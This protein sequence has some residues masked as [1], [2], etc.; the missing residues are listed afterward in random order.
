M[1]GRAPSASLL[2]RAERGEIGGVI[3]LRPQVDDERQ[4]RA[5]ATALQEAATAGGQPP[6]LL[7]ADQEGGGVRTLGWAQPEE[8]ALLMGRRRDVD[9]VRSLGAAAGKALVGA[10]LNVDLAPVGDVPGSGRS[11]MRDSFRTWSDDPET[12]GRFAG[13]FAEGLASQDVLA[14]AKHFPGIGRVAR[15]TDRFVETVTESREALERDLEP[16]RALIDAG[17]PLV[18][19]SNATYEAL[20]PD[21]AAGW[22]EAVAGDLLR[23]DL[24]F[25]GVTITD[26]LNGTAAA[27]DVPASSLAVAA[28]RAGVDLVLLTGRERS[29]ADAYGLLLREARE[30]TLDRATLEAGHARI[31]ALKATLADE[32]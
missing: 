19:L 22:S 28:A 30:G 27:R 18:M 20:D 5:A 15:N 29:T 10:G 4:L 1:D 9:E 8:A 16:F 26:S 32:R 14:T 12:V 24:G 31:L 7:M 17:V 23:D 2:G 21:N 3:F 11:F 6:L 13:A 25:T